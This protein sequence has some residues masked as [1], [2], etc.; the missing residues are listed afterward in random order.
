MTLH[1]KT[2]DLGGERIAYLEAGGAHSRSA[3][4]LILL[5]GLGHSSTAW[6]RAIPALAQR[7]RVLVPDMPGYGRSGKPDAAY[8]PPYFADFVLRFVSALR[9]APAYAAGSSLGGLVLMLAALSQPQALRQLVLADPLGFTKPPRPPLDDAVLA[10]IGWWLSFRRTRALIRAGYASIFFDQTKV[11]EETVDEIVL[12]QSDPARMTAARRT[13]RHIFHF[14]KHLDE[15][16]RRLRELAPRALVI[17]GRNDP[18]LPAKDV[19]IAQRVLPSPRIEVLE[20][21]GHCP[22]IERPEAFCS[23]VLDFL[24]EDR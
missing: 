8:D 6:H 3:H 4:P 19:D 17:W 24:N 10:I 23:L 9:L 22:H 12:R 11:D 16:H 14:S 15:L 5:H 2:I 7:Y 13:V 1:N 20:R 21:C 18:V